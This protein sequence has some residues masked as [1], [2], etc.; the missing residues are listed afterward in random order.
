ML[1]S[2]LF[3]CGVRDQEGTLLLWEVVYFWRRAQ[4]C[5]GG[6]LTKKLRANWAFTRSTNPRVILVGQPSL[7]PSE[8]KIG[9]KIAE[10]AWILTV[11]LPKTFPFRAA[12]QGSHLVFDR[13]VWHNLQLLSGWGFFRGLLLSHKKKKIVARKM[14]TSCATSNMFFGKHLFREFVTSFVLHKT[15]F[16][17]RIT[18]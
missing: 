8:Q 1:Y 3:L 16:H 5:F 9:E 10:I 15:T 17:A 12:K 14:W 4:L 11:S 2:P 13:W 7:V 6:F 18:S